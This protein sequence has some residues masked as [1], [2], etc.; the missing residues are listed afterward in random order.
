M[1]EARTNWQQRTLPELCMDLHM[2]FTGASQVMTLDEARSCA[3][4]IAARVTK[5]TVN[6]NG[7]RHVAFDT[8]VLGLCLATLAEFKEWQTR[9]PVVS[10][11]R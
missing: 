6:A 3:A 10:M 7:D 2:E 8:A 4:R 1:S 5:W 9:F 11:S